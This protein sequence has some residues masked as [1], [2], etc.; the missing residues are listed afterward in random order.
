MAIGI[1]VVV[2][3]ITMALLMM[4]RKIPALL[5]LP[6]MAVL[7]GLAGGL[8]L[9][10]QEGILTYVLSSGALKLAGTYVAILFSCWLSQILY[11]T[12]V[13]DTIVKKAAEFGGD[14]PVIISICLS[15]VTAFL[16]TVLYGTGAVAM[17]GSIVLPIMLSV[18]VQPVVAANAYLAAM[19]AGYVINPANIAVITNITGV[20]ASS[21]YLCAAILSVMSILFA[22]GYLVISFRKG[23]RK[24]AFATPLATDENDEERPQQVTGVRG[25]LAC[26]TPLVVV[27]VMLIFRLEAITVFIIGIIWAMIFTFKGNWTKYSG[28][29]VQSCYEGFKEGAPTTGLMFGIGMIIN[30]MTAPI[31]QAAI[32]PFM[33]AITPTTAAGLILFVCLL[34]PL[35]LYR[36]PFNLLGLGA[37]LAAS[38]LA[39]NVLPVAA[40]SAVF[41][42]AFRWPTQSCPTSTQVVWAS[43]YVGQ[44]PVG[45]TNKVFFANW[46][47]TTISVIVMVL[48]YF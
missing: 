18:G 4:L 21:M 46:I 31:T 47:L 26:M 19:T 24:F 37:G 2:I 27:A 13:T 43:N 42:A 8:P 22:I 48:I 6:V 41:Y 10:G 7:I 15:I 5:A 33:E 23:G 20:A 12:G 14:K 11:R 25:F 16:F 45:T 9:V 40:L 38:M 36:G 34:S 35:G 3:F 29:I 17:V 32:N 1:I 44:D 30:A 39:V 28:M